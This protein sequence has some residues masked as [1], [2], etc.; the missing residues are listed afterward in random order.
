MSV[1]LSPLH[2][3]NARLAFARQRLVLAKGG[4]H[5]VVVPSGP[6]GRPGE[7]LL[8]PTPS[9]YSPRVVSSGTREDFRVLLDQHGTTLASVCLGPVAERGD[10]EESMRKTLGGVFPGSEPKTPVIAEEPALRYCLTFNSGE[11]TEW[12]FSHREWLFVTGVLTRGLNPEAAVETAREVLS[13][14]R[15]IEG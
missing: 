15:W 2:R 7:R 8:S 4:T 12:K 6:D 1:L 11:L 10:P 13:T 9:F 14:W 3:V 5:K